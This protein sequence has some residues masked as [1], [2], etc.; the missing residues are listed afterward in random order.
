MRNTPFSRLGRLAAMPPPTGHGLRIGL[1]GGSFNPPHAAHALIS[2]ITLK[3]LQLDRL[4]WLVTPGNPLKSG[5]E[6]MPLEQRIADCQALVRDPRIVVTAFEKDL[7]TAYTAATLDF[8]TQ[9]LPDTHFVWIMG[10]DCLVHFHR[11]QQWQHIFEKIPIA[12][13]D[14]PGCR[15]PALASPAARRYGTSRIPESRAASL[16]TMRAPAWTFLGGP[17]SPLSSTMLRRQGP[18]LDPNSPQSDGGG[19]IT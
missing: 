2:E 5:A 9:R 14:R 6:L 15:L 10:A 16:A 1:L 4:W 13:V 18:G 19:A 11:W 7:P 17:L 3:R 12:V 8:L